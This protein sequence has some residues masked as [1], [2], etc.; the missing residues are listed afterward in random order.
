MQDVSMNFNLWENLHLR[1]VHMHHVSSMKS[2]L[3]HPKSTDNNMMVLTLDGKVSS[4]QECLS[5]V[6]SPQLSPQFRIL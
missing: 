5:S 6:P 2:G 1:Q 3:T 4:P